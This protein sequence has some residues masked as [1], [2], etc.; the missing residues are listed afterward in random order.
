MKEQ[1]IQEKKREAATDLERIRNHPLFQQAYKRL[2]KAEKERIFCCH[3]IDHLLDVARIAYIQNLE[4]GLGFSKE[5]IYAAA[6]LHDI[7]KASQ[8]EEQIPHEIASA[9][10]AEII[11]QETHFTEEEKQQILQAIRGHRKMKEE[12][13]TFEGLLYTSDKKSRLCFV[14]PAEAE[15]NWSSDKKNMEMEI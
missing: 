14:C 4:Q 13:T 3:Q 15:C 9:E 11:L 7:G 12:M 2:K 5:M 1:S 10:L 8:Y 6:L